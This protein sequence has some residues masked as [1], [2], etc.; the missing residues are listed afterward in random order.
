MQKNSLRIQL[1]KKVF[2]SFYRKILMVRGG[3]RKEPAGVLFHTHPPVGE[4]WV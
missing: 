3:F 1:V 4:A 2:V